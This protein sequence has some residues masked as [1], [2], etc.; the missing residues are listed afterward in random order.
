MCFPSSIHLGWQVRLCGSVPAKGL[1]H[2]SHWDTQPT[3]CVISDTKP[4]PINHLPSW[5][6]TT[7][8]ISRISFIGSIFPIFCPFLCLMALVPTADSFL[9][10]VMGETCAYFPGSL[11]KANIIPV[12]PLK[13]DHPGQLFSRCFQA[14]YWERALIIFFFPPEKELPL[15]P[16]NYW[17][18]PFYSHLIP[19]YFSPHFTGSWQLSFLNPP[20]TAV[21]YETR[22]GEIIWKLLTGTIKWTK[23]GSSICKCSSP[24]RKNF[25]LIYQNTPLTL[26]SKASSVSKIAKAQKC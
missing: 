19:I 14:N 8:L 4:T 16:F 26:K 25:T 9:P 3:C 12:S 11:Q 7:Q 13:P 6:I 23:T 21:P 1:S 2:P 10:L 17:L 15:W 5:L 24:A 22:I 18:C 20:S